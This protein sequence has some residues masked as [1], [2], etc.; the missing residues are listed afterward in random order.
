MQWYRRSLAG[1]GW[2]AAFGIAVSLALGTA[3]SSAQTV[4]LDLK[5]TCLADEVM[6]EGGQAALNDARRQRDAAAQTIA[7]GIPLFR[8][9][10]MREPIAGGEIGFGKNLF[11][12]RRTRGAPPRALVRD[13]ETSR[14]GWVNEELIASFSQSLR[15]PD[16]PGFES[17]TSDSGRPN[18]LIAKVVVRSRS[19]ERGELAQVPIYAAPFPA[20]QDGQEV[21]RVG[22]FAVQEVFRIQNARRQRCSINDPD[23]FLLIGGTRQNDADSAPVASI[24]GW[25]S[26]QDVELWPS[27]I[28]I[29]Y[30]EGR[31]KI[32]VFGDEREARGG[33]T[34]KAVAIENGPTVEPSEKNIPR[35]PV[36]FRA[37][38]RGPVGDRDIYQIV[39]AGRVCLDLGCQRTITAAESFKR[40]GKIG[41][42][43]Y[44]SE[45]IDVLFVVDA[46]KSMS[47]YYPAV[48]SAVKGVVERAKAEN[49][50]M[51]FS[52]V[53]YGDY[54]GT[55]G[56]PATVDYVDVSGG[57]RGT[58]DA[59]SVVG[60]D[61]LK[62]LGDEQVDYPE[63]P[64][65]A[66]T[67]AVTEARWGKLSDTA[68][69]LV[70]WIGD[71]G[72]RQPG[73]TKT[74]S[75]AGTVNETV[76]SDTV[77][78]AFKKDPNRVITFAAINV[79]GDYLAQFNEG[80]RRNARE[81]IAKLGTDRTLG[82]EIVE[83]TINQA[84]DV[85]ATE[86]AIREKLS[87]IIATS[88]SIVGHLRRGLTGGEASVDGLPYATLARTYIRD[89]LKISD[90]D[91]KSAQG[92]IREIRR[93]F[94]V[95][96]DRDGDFR[97]WLALRPR[98]RN[99]L[100]DAM[101]QLCLAFE[102]NEIVD[103]TIVAMRAVLQ[104]ATF[105]EMAR[106]DDPNIAEFLEKR[107]SVPRRNFAQI[108]NK[109]LSQYVR[110]YYKMTKEDQARESS[111]IC[112]R[113][114][115]LELISDSVRVREEDIERAGGTWRVRRG[116]K[117]E[118]FQWSWTVDSSVTYFFVPLEFLP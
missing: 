47:R 105:E 68:L 28:S 43:I 33:D 22:Y 69:N 38:T 17:A 26:A 61:R 35:F 72:N 41:E 10:D 9:Q 27:A 36:L 13:N 21:G 53:A 29:Y 56:T 37:P 8:T 44:R 19:N 57:F 93:G 52:V 71:H 16:I 111:R 118:P 39:F 116:V 96:N 109:P 86:L 87:G 11:V 20:G 2:P 101:K 75:K 106:D 91:L 7:K 54:R 99:A 107:L 104:A 60:L 63:A 81:L 74:G 42:A 98:E 18:R 115:L 78:Q 48:I 76:T 12:F 23:C 70:I 24:L 108:L 95:Q 67:K 79:R 89:V 110:E 113:S 88:A 85:A 31:T 80:F 83:N 51:R 117:P 64:F 90:E 55:E 100:H 32:P 84:S 40:L 6:F 73:N 34:A 65:A 62:T 30:R 25:V 94:V 49:I 1:D 59:G 77:A 45:G 58:N 114:L 66:L 46:T 5:G 4:S 15:V 3:Q 112:R 102:S 82:L 103:E 14:C 50:R 97:F 92:Q